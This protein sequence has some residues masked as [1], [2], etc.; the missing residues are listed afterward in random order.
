MDWISVEDELPQDFENVLIHPQ[1]EYHGTIWE[2][3]YNSRKRE[4]TAYFEDQ[5]QS[6][7]EVV[8]V[9]HWMR[10]ELPNHSG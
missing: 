5:Y 4:W 10:I 3:E 9:T 6:Y 2:G 8:K 1:P 7:D